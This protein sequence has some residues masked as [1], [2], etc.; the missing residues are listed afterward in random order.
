M[1][2]ITDE[3]RDLAYVNAN[4]K[5]R[6][7]YSAPESGKNLRIIADKYGL[8][9]NKIYYDFVVL[10]G[11]VVLNLVSRAKLPVLLS[12]KLRINSEV[13]VKITGEIID[14]LDTSTDLSSDIAET[15]A[16]LKQTEVKTKFRTMADDI[17][18]S[19]SYS[20]SDAP[21]YTSS[22]TD[23]LT[24][25]APIPKPADIPRWSSETE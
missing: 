25:K 20:T 21:V 6:Y 13:A 23:L 10:I 8:T 3:Q 5:Q 12:E 1:E 2:I 15:E 19:Q 16:A 14:F 9:D 7:L 4:D 18:Q 22:Q 17:K 24:P 11:D